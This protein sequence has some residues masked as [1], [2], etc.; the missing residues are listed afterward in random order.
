MMRNCFL[1]V[2]LFIMTSK[3][4]VKEIQSTRIIFCMFKKKVALSPKYLGCVLQKK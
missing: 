1:S 4:L 3:V 2:F